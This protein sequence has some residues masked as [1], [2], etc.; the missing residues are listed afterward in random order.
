MLKLSD[1]FKIV[2]IAYW[3]R[4]FV[5]FYSVTCSKKNPKSFLLEVL[6][7][8]KL[9]FTFYKTNGAIKL[10]AIYWG[11]ECAASVMVVRAKPERRGHESTW[12]WQKGPVMV[13]SSLFQLEVKVGLYL[14]LPEGLMGHEAIINA[15]NRGWNLLGVLQSGCKSHLSFPSWV[16]TVEQITRVLWALA[17]SLVNWR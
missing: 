9:L 17:P 3:I 7:T 10:Q 14:S 1:W 8:L 15:L 6:R 5:F 16:R 11:P 4:G 13:K 12:A 2:W